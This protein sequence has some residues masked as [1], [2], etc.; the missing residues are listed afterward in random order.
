MVKILADTM[1]TKRTVINLIQDLA[2]PHNNVLIEQFRD[3]TDVEIKLW[4]AMEQDSDLYQWHTDISHEH[5][6]ANIYGNQ[7]NWA[8]LR[9]CLGHPHEKFVVVGWMNT[10][11][12]LLHL[13]YFLLRRPYNHWTDLPEPK[14][15]GMSLKQR[16]LRW[17]A[18]RLLKHS[19]CKIFG[20]GKTSMDCFRG[21]GFPPER[22]V[23]LPIFVT[24]DEDFAVYQAQRNELLTRYGVFSGGFLISG[25]S[26]LIHEKGYDLLIRAVALLP[27]DIRAELKVVIVGSG[28]VLTE[29]RRLAGELNLSACIVFEQWLAI[30]DFKALIANS[31][32]F[33]HPAR[34]DSYG[35]TTLGMALGVPVI[36]S[37]GAGA[38]VDRIEPGLNGFLYEAEDIQAL[39]DGIVR[40]YRNPELKQR[41]GRAARE[42]A[43]NWHPSRGVDIIL[44]N[45]I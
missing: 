3:R 37:T 13:L 33:V 40:L 7:F 31:D 20:V 35:G 36:G 2:T 6:R 9:Y 23:N 24:V 26:R 21:W 38:A 5:F 11:T 32:V 18:Y 28:D 45:A 43:L 10:N 25:G 30:G 17:A 14:M 1:Q 44:K 34:F 41:M 29:L 16:F 39:A 15:V 4:Y 42:T 22:L 8:F 12:R 19:Y 27:E